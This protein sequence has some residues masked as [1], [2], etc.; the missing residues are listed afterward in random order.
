MRVLQQKDSLVFAIDSLST[1][2]Y[3]LFNAHGDLFRE[4]I[5]ALADP[6]VK[7]LVYWNL[8]SPN[9]KKDDADLGAI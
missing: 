6:N 3:N 1:G 7:G 9:A 2:I 5:T 8:S 4:T